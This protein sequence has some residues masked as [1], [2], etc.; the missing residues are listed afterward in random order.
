MASYADT[1]P[2]KFLKGQLVIMLLAELRSWT[3]SGRSRGAL[4]PCREYLGR[5]DK[6]GAMAPGRFRRPYAQVVR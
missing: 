6:A 5:A 3:C 1:A 4:V 2:A